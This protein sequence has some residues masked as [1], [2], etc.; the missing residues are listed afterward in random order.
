MNDLL[1]RKPTL[2]ELTGISDD[3]LT[4]FATQL[5]ACLGRSVVSNAKSSGVLPSGCPSEDDSF[6]SSVLQ[7]T[8]SALNCEKMSQFQQDSCQGSTSLLKCLPSRN[9]TARERLMQTGHD[10]LP[11]SSSLALT[12]DVNLSNDDAMGHA[13]GKLP[14]TNLV[15]SFGVLD[16][17]DTFGKPLDLPPFPPFETFPSSSSSPL[18]PQYCWCPSP[19]A[20]TLHYTLRNSRIPSLSSESFLLPPLSTLLSA[21]AG[22]SKS[23]RSLSEASAMD[24]PS[25]Q[26]ETL[27]SSL[28]TSQQ[29]PTFKPLTC[30]PIVPIPIY[31]S[32]PSYLV[33]AGPA[34]TTTIPPLNLNLGN[35]PLVPTSEP[36]VVQSARETLRMLI[37]ST[38]SDEKPNA[39]SF[40][41]HRGGRLYPCPTTN[42]SFMFSRGDNDSVDRQDTDSSGFDN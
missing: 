12:N 1:I 19:I 36:A 20:S 42:T 32:G 7:F 6:Y 10:V 14:E 16:A 13:K 24:F 34:I 23:S 27:V 3:R 40:G 11:N 5:K 21:G 31:S 4:S 18:S 30:D 35:P 8:Q 17:V 22:S 28:P 33:S 26:P 29:I 15:D 39:V 9:I 25:F 38:N 37:H 2:A 41:G